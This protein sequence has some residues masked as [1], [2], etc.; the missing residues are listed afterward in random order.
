VRIDGIDVRQYSLHSLR[1]QVALVLQDT[2]LFE[3][4]LLEN[5]LC[6]RLGAAAHE[7]MRAAALAHVDEFAERLPDGYQTVLSEHG[8]DLSGGQRQRVA[9]ARALLKDAPILILDEPTSALDGESEAA[10]M[11]AIGN[12][13]RGRTTLI[14]AHRLSTIAGADRVI[15]LGD[16]RACEVDGPTP[17]APATLRRRPTPSPQ[18]LN[19]LRPDTRSVV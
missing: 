17:H 8:L 18:P 16:G 1:D 13:I 19:H 5:I 7:V 14:I 11:D 15:A 4:T 10:V 12:L 9:I 3:G 2:A 6:G